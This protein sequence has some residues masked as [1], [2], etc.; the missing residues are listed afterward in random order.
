M[1]GVDLQV[2]DDKDAVAERAAELL[3]EAL[4]HVALSG[5]STPK[6]AYALAAGAGPKSRSV[7]NKTDQAGDA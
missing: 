3:R 1:S 6:Q 2:L 7:S 4:G 5:G